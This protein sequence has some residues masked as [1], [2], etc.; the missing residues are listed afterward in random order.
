M[1]TDISDNAPDR[2]AH[3]R[4]RRHCQASRTPSVTI[5]RN[6][7]HPGGSLATEAPRARSAQS[8]PNARPS[9]A[10]PH[11]QA[12]S[13]R[14]HQSQQQANTHTQCTGHACVWYASP[15]QVTDGEGIASAAMPQL[16]DVAVVDMDLPARSAEI[17]AVMYLTHGTVH[18]YLASAVTE[19]GARDRSTRSASQPRPAGYNPSPVA[20]RGCRVA[21]HG[22]GTTLRGFLPRAWDHLVAS[23]G[24]TRRA[25][26]GVLIASGTRSSRSIDLGVRDGIPGGCRD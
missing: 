18:N 12:P 14:S 10:R 23:D 6:R 2:D 1:T 9:G 22:H 15:V 26:L 16:P 21:C 3:K 13:R 7:T 4:G 8:G 17:A 11:A 19:L 25:G 5:R 20:H 24:T